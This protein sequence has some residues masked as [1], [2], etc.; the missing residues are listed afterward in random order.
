M[1]LNWFAY[2]EIIE[3]VTV[4]ISLF[5]LQHVNGL[6][7]YLSSLHSYALIMVMNRYADTVDC[8]NDPDYFASSASI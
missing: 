3:Q 2:G 5:L 6:L 1:S 4:S 8:R 7:R